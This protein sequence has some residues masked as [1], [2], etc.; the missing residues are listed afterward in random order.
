M[1]ISSATYSNFQTGFRINP[2]QSLKPVS[3]T[4]SQEPET[5][6]ESG[7]PEPNPNVQ[8]AKETVNGRELELNEIKLLE[9]LKKADAEVRQHEMAHVAAGGRYITSGA[10][11][12]YKQGPDGKNY[13]VSIWSKKGTPV[14]I[15][16]F[17]EPSKSKLIL[18]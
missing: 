8:P 11:F 17:P 9:A 12:N 7:S 10:S 6:Q 13:A 3:D 14:E 5:T 16:A 1:N 2:I 4:A 15:S 18:T